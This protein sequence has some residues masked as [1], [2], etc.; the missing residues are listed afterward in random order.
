MK[1]IA[2][3]GK[4]KLSLEPDLIQLNLDLDYSNLD[5]DKTL[6]GIEE[7]NKQLKDSIESLSFN[8]SDIKTTK[9]NIDAVYK[10][11]KYKEFGE[12][13]QKRVFDGYLG[14]HNL[15]FSFDYDMGKLSKILNSIISLKNPPEFHI[16]YS[17]KDKEGAKEKLLLEATKDA[18]RKAE[19][20]TTA[21]NV[22]LGDLINITYSWTNINF[23][24][25]ADYF[26][27]MSCKSIG[28]LDITPE[29]IKMEDEVEFIWEIK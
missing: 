27:E 11:V 12:T 14:E 13:Q 5:Y 6:M 15:T 4:G 8:R 7:S 19:I 10:W 16:S 22:T 20:L 2:I 9:F 21:S 1:T 18:R 28:S 17:V 26:E 23:T 29:D 25:N 3:K 24:R